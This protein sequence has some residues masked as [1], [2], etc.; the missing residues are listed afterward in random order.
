MNF[1]FSYMLA[2]AQSD[3]PQKGDTALDHNA[4]RV[5]G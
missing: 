4:K 5:L 2:N 1:L 3:G